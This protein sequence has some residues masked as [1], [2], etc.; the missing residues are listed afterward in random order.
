M[1][2]ALL[3][4][5]LVRRVD[6]EWLVGLIVETEA[7][8]KDDPA[9]HAF[10]GPT[11]RNRA[12]FGPAGR[13]YVYFI[14]GNHW[15]FNVVCHREG[16]GEAVLV[17]AVEPVRGAA[18]M[19]ARRKGCGAIE[20][21]NGPAKLC[22]AMAIDGSHDGLDLTVSS[23]A[24]YLA[25]NPD[26]QAV[27]SSTGPVVVTTRIGLRQAAD[28]PLRFYLQ[29]SPWVSRRPKGDLNVVVAPSSTRAR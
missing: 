16:V 20:L 15:C 13:A 23:S 17:R 25:A 9:C 7:Y 12:M 14:Y 1:A 8:L 10:R 27:V 29:G 26:R 18:G 24:I 22:Q 28:S 21:T 11:R 3:G 2:P 4:H 19:A 5:W 6:D